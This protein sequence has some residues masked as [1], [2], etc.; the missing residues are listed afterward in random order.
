MPKNL[1]AEAS[2]SVNAT[3]PVVWDALVN[4]DAIKRYMFGTDV[5]S[6]FKKGSKITWKGEWKGKPYEDKGVILEV[7]ER[8]KL[9]YTHFS[10]MTGKPDSPENYHTVTIEL[11]RDGKG[12]RVKLSQDNNETEEERSHSQENWEMMLDGLKKYVES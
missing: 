1:V 11:S 7:D 8:K 5:T 4:P 2:T 10:P 3:A 6:N 12:T 9:Q